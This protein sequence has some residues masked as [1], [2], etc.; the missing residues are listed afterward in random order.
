MLLQSHSSRCNVHLLPALPPGWH[1]G[2]ALGMQARGALSI[3]LHW[4]GGRLRRVPA[5]DLR[6]RA[7]DSVYAANKLL[8]V[9]VQSVDE[10]GQ[11]MWGP[12]PRPFKP[13]LWASCALL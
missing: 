1:Q 4:S 2:V 5:R 7:A 11:S 6:D 8:S 13:G 3:D 9:G 10:H 12:H